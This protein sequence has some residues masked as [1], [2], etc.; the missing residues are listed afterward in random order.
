MS[1]RAKLLQAIMA[2]VVVTTVASLLIAQRQNS[3]SYRAVLDDLFRHQLSSFQQEEE[4][5]LTVA[6][7]EAQRLADSV[8]LF[9]ALEANDPEVYKIAGDELRLGDFAFFRLLNARGEIIAPPADGRAGLPGTQALHRQLNPTLAQ[10]TA[11]IAKVQLGYIEVRHGDSAQV[12]RVVA[13]PITNFGTVVGT[14]ILGQRIMALGTGRAGEQAAHRLRSG[15]WLDGRLSGDDM[16]GA[17][18]DS[19]TATLT[20]AQ[21]QVLTEGQIRAAGEAYRFER[22]LLNEGSSYPPAYL[23]SVFSL[24]EFQSQQ[25]LLVL[26]IALTGLVALLLAAL[27]GRWLSRQL[28]Q[29]IRDLVSA[30]REIRKGNYGVKLSPSSTREMNTLAESFNDMAAGLALKDRYHSVLHQ[31]TDPQVAEEL[32]AGR[33]RLGGELRE[34]TVVFCD[35]RGYTAM[36]VGRDPA[37]VIEILNS[38]LSALTHIVQAHRG[39]ISQFVGDAIFTLF[40]APKSYGDDAERA[41]HC[42]WAMMCERER[43]NRESAEPLHIGIGI[44]SGQMVAGCIGAESRSDYVV[45]GERVNLAAR[46]CSAAAAGEILI[47]EETRIRAGNAV[48]SESLQPLSLKGFSQ[49]V[50]VFRILGVQDPPS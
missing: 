6:A 3:D 31:V 44:A 21:T 29:P 20:G 9:A 2:I 35:I 36:T 27:V 50:S 49:P 7:E 13:S 33:V 46:L 45:V 37:E 43:M 25:R 4:I 19:L 18:R 42:A 32:I 15:F 26:R 23:V 11:R 47:D 12:F 14:L 10:E 34:V 16:P 1:F 41:V 22:F 48:S 40:G 39:V 38:H 5:R 28:A 30:T 24:A 17:V 8:R